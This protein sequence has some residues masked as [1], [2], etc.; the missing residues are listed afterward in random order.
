MSSKKP[1]KKPPKP[2]S[3]AGP[4]T[5]DELLD[6]LKELSPVDEDFARDLEEIRGLQGTLPEDP[7]AS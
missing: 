6:L 2:H 7:W 4:K 3:P 5:L 1:Q